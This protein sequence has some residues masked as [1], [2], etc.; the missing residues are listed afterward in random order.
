M[1]STPLVLSSEN[2]WGR[3]A[4]LGWKRNPG[5]DRYRM[6]TKHYGWLRPNLTLTQS[7]LRRAADLVGIRRRQWRRKRTDR[8][9]AASWQTPPFPIRDEPS[10]SRSTTIGRKWAFPHCHGGDWRCQAWSVPRRRRPPLHGDIASTREIGARRSGSRCEDQPANTDRVDDSESASNSNP[11]SVHASI[12]PSS[13]RTRLAP[14]AMSCC[15]MLA[16]DASLG[17]AQ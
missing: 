10:L 2:S 1:S 11:A 17:Q 5:E 13:G 16:A 4:P 9:M 3:E 7:E 15:A 14:R 6:L 12:P 8:R